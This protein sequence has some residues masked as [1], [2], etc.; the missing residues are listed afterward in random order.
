MK[1][2]HRKAILFFMA[3]SVTVSIAACGKKKNEISDYGTESVASQSDS[4]SIGEDNK[5][6]ANEFGSLIDKLETDKIEWQESF[7]VNGVKFNIKLDY[8]VPDISQVPIYTLETV[9]DTD[10]REK[11]ILSVL[12]GNEYEEIHEDFIYS[13]NVKYED[14]YPLYELVYNTYYTFSGETIDPDVLE[15]DMK[16]WESV[17]S[18]E[19]HSY[20]GKYD[21]KEYYAVFSINPEKYLFALSLLPVDLKEFMEDTAVSDYSE[22][23]GIEWEDIDSNEHEVIDD[24]QNKCVDKKDEIKEK[25]EKFINNTLGALGKTYYMCQVYEGDSNSSS[26]SAG[27]DD[28]IFSVKDNGVYTQIRFINDDGSVFYDGY[29][30]FVTNDFNN[31]NCLY[32]GT[33]LKSKKEAIDYYWGIYFCSK[34]LLYAQ[35][36]LGYLYAEPSVNDTP[37]LS[38]ESIKEALKEQI[39]YKFNS[40]ESS[41]STININNLDFVYYPINNPDKE[42]E[43]TFVPAWDFSIWPHNIRVVINAVDGSILYIRYK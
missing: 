28:S 38:F 18:F 12:F 35:L 13:E 21:N 2:I 39:K 11:E 15:E 22:F 14:N 8:D 43:F 16:T 41:I 30:L 31:M 5:A 23:Y 25:A 33:K 1:K 17:G 20:K 26:V 27:Y 34:G 7:D 3:V 24:A 6:K 32:E 19:I 4:G 10:K 40:S 37:L 29:P 9:S 36:D 42:N